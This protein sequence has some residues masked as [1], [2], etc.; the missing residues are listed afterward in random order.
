M[1]KSLI[2]LIC[3]LIMGIVFISGCTSDDKTN[4][5]TLTNSQS[6]EKSDTQNPDLI[7]KQ[8]D[9]PGL[10]LYSYSFLAFPKNAVY[11]WA[12]NGS[13]TEYQDSLPLGY[14]DVG[15]KS[16]WRDQSGRQVEIQLSKYESYPTTESME[17]FTN[18]ADIM[19]KELEEGRINSDY[20]WGDPH[21]G[22]YSR[23]IAVITDSNIGIQSTR[24]TFVYNKN[25]VTMLVT[26]EKDKSIKEAIRI[27]KIIKSRLS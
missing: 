7:I 20:D 4:S 23:Y 21:I 19:E 24:L 18:F 16:E 22:D 13:R 26:D 5:E 3:I 15:E 9:V 2:I 1:R 14:R 12:P 27:A 25:H 10:T 11:D 17:S 6:N 8:S